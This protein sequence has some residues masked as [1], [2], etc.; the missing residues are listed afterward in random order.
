M[1]KREGASSDKAKEERVELGQILLNSVSSR[2]LVPDK[3]KLS[4]S[5]GRPIKINSDN[6]SNHKST[7]RALP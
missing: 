7:C 4:S 5:N 1:C 2:H 3:Y 6:V